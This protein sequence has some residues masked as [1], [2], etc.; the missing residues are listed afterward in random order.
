MKEIT[1]S[2][3]GGK[4]IDAKVG[5]FSVRTDQSSANGGGETAPEPFQ[6]F[7]A[8]IATCA[9]IYALEF[10]QAR[11]IPSEG[12]GLTMRCEWDEKQ[13]RVD[14]LHIELKVPP[15]FPDRYKKAMVRVMDLCTVKKHI[16]HPPEFLITTS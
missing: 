15:G 5:D 12:M 3:P 4:K 8:S 14:K 2:F 7:L 1:V 13:Q 11:E 16:A 10:C 6:L 9:G